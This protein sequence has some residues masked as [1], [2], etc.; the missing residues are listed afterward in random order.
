[1]LEV[2]AKA[3]RHACEL[4]GGKEP[5]AA[6]LKVPVERLEAWMAR[7][8]VPP[9]GIF[10]S[11]VE[12][13]GGGIPD[14]A[15]VPGEI[16]QLREAVRTRHDRVRSAAR[17]RE[18]KEAVLSSNGD[19]VRPPRSIVGFLHAAFRPDE[20]RE[21]IESALDAA[22]GGTGADMGNI[23]IE[24]PEGLVIVAQRGFEAP[25]LDFFSC[26]KQE[27]SCGAARRVADRVVVADVQ[28]D[29]I[30]VGTDSA[31]IMEQARARACQSTPL[32]DASGA[33]V[34][35]LN[36]HYARPR[37]PCEQ[38]LDVLDHIAKRTTFWLDGGPA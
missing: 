18:F 17:A 19:C 32:I 12:I 16:L 33:V 35:M 30:F 7:D 14:G 9:I 34:G 38:E 29:P 3:L 24:S 25:F 10:L 13:I 26:V 22:V 36:T 8:E 31:E 6:L 1:M 2:Y 37:R 27:G 5:L 20:G 15:S 21:M 4:A 28:S 23:Q 11:A